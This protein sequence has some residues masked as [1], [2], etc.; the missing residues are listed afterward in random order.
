MGQTL[1]IAVFLTFQA[2]SNHENTDRA[3]GTFKL[4]S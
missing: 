3:K 2:N 4:E 1:Y